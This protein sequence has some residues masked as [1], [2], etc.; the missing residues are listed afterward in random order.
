MPREITDRYG[1]VGKATTGPA[2][3]GQVAAG[4]QSGN[5]RLNTNIVTSF[6]SAGYRDAA[7]LFGTSTV[8]SSIRTSVN[9]LTEGLGTVTLAWIEQR[10]GAGVYNQVG[11]T[12]LIGGTSSSS[13]LNLSYS[14]GL[15]NNVF[16]YASGFYDLRGN[17]GSGVF[18]GLTFT[19]GD[20]DTGNLGYNRQ[21]KSNTYSGQIQRSAVKPGDLGWRVVDQEGDISRR[22]A[23]VQY[24]SGI[25][26]VTGGIDQ[27]GR[28]VAGRAGVSGSVVLGGG[29]AFLADRV[30][31]S[32][33]IVRADHLPRVPVLYENR[34]VAETRWDGRAL[35]PQLRSF[36]ANRLSIDSTGLPADIEVDRSVS[37]VR[38]GDRS[39][40]VVDFGVRRSL[41]ALVRFALADGRP[42]PIGSVVQ[43]EGQPPA[44]V[45]R[46]GRAYLTGLGP[47]NAVRIEIASDGTC[48][49]RF[50]FTPAAGDIP[51]IGPV[52]CE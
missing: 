27:S 40:V 1:A 10:G 25:G 6:A 3:G 35:V 18:A 42:V 47:R 41:G 34:P 51:L 2:Q 22:L 19:F 5:T 24:L 17:V 4:L 15:M 46:D 28:D 23:E 26:R 8:R 33:A 20:R 29:S 30:Y 48:E 52:R 45:G 12:R 37:V 44:P 16:V 9:L 14:L 36:D 32:F 13:L 38:P 50:D 21:D 7:A 49:A 11:G 31:D 43:R 39:G